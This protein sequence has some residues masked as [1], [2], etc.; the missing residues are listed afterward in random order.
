[1][2]PLLWG[3]GGSAS[4][5]KQVL[6]LAL[7]LRH[8]IMIPEWHSAGTTSKDILVLVPSHTSYQKLTTVENSSYP[9]I[10]TIKYT[11][12]G[13]LDAIIKTQWPSKYNFFKSKVHHMTI[14]LQNRLNGNDTDEEHNNCLNDETNYRRACIAIICTN[15][16]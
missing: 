12:T 11:H 4:S 3:F 13:Y 9:I 5:I 6:L 10:T 16:K 15:C 1:M 8:L 2:I 14:Y 7:L